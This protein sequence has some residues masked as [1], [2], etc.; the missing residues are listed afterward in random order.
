M[1]V[2]GDAGDGLKAVTLARQ[3]TPHVVIMGVSLPNLNGIEAT[4]QILADYPAIKI[5]AFSLH[6][7]RHQILNMLKVGACGYLLIDSHFEELV[8]AIRLVMDGKTYLTPGVTDIV[9]RNY[10]ESGLPY[11]QI[12]LS[13]LT[14]REREVLR[15]IAEGKSSKQIAGLLKISVKTVE[16]YRQNVMRKLGTHSVAGLTKYTLREGLTSLEA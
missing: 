15:L 8:K 12:G 6:A 1:E 9:V 13:Q 2:V 7:D 11:D 14:A 4:R 5:I 16:T 10:L 3:L